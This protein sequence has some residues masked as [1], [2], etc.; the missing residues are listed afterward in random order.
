MC[1]SSHYL[2]YVLTIFTN[3]GE[4]SFITFSQST[5]TWQNVF[6]ILV[7]DIPCCL[8][9][10]LASQCS[11]SINY[12]TLLCK[13]SHGSSSMVLYSS[14]LWDKTFHLVRKLVKAKDAWKQSETLHPSKEL[15][16]NENNS[17]T[18][19]IS[20]ICSCAPVPTVSK[21]AQA[22]LLRDT[23]RPAKLPRTLSNQLSCLEEDIS[24]GDCWQEELRT[25]DLP[26]EDTIQSMELPTSC[27]EHSRYPA[28]VRCH[29]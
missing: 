20:R 22:G 10:T 4:C 9:S 19:E 6:P 1:L 7:E 14:V 29:V 5:T 12:T 8:A 26:V 27:G 28:F 24:H 15:F 25:V 3:L 16:K 11:V 23:L 17:K 18:S 2:S 13:Y 21:Y